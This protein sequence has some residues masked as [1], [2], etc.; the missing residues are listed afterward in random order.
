MSPRAAASEERRDEIL[1]AA[2][3]VFASKGLDRARMEDIADETGLSKGALYLYFKSKDDLIIA[4][5]DRI[6]QYEFKQL[7]ELHTGGSSAVES[8]W[9]FV[10]IAARDLKRMQPLM[11]IAYEFLA[12]AFRNNTVNQFVRQYLRRYLSAL[13]PVIEHGIDTGEFRQVDPLE[14]ALAIGAIFE[15]TILIWMYDRDTV[16]LERHIHTGIR[17]LLDGIENRE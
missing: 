7:D 2:E 5:M 14:T 15:G 1:D 3:Q 9:A 11:P 6:F 4:I 12:M 13:V 10:D 16:D 17:L 8:L